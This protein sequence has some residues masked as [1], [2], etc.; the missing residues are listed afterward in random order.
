MHFQVFLVVSE[1]CAEVT[2]GGTEMF[3]V[4]REKQQ[5]CS[6]DADVVK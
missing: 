6:Q 3:S 5:H 1:D 4:T 2:L